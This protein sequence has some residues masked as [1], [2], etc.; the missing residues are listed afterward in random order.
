M[1]FAQEIK[2]FIAGAQAGQKMIGASSDE[3]YKAAK[4]K[5]LEAQ[6]TTLVNKNN[7]EEGDKLTK[8]AQRA[9]IRSRDAATALT[10]RRGALVDAQRKALT[11]PPTPPATDPMLAGLK[12]T[13]SS[14][15]TDV[16]APA[17]AVG[18]P[19]AGLSPDLPPTPAVQPSAI[20]ATS[21]VPADTD[22]DPV[23]A[24]SRGGSVQKFADGGAVGEAPDEEDPVD[25]GEPSPE[26]APMP[27]AVGGASD[28][29]DISARSRGTPKFSADA[30]L[31]A[32]KAGL[33]YAVTT[34]GL[35]SRAAV[36]DPQRQ[37][38]LKAY[39]SGAGAAQSTD[40]VAVRKAIDPEG[41]LGESSANLA[42]L[43]AVYQYKMN[44]GDEAGAQRAAFAM[45][46]HYRVSS[47]QY[48][49][50]AAAAAEKG[51]LDNATK[52]VMKSYAN[53]PDGKDLKLSKTEDGKIS[54]S[55]TDEKTGKVI[56]K[57]IET[58]DKLA[59]TAIGFARGQG[60]DAA[61]LAAAGQ[62]AEKPAKG[63]KGAVDPDA[64][65]KSA[66]KKTVLTAVNQAYDDQNPA[67]SEDE[68]KPKRDKSEERALRGASFRIAAHPANNRLTPDEAV[69]VATKIADPAALGKSTLKVDKA[70]GGYMVSIDKRPPTFVTA[71]DMGTLMER[72]NANKAGLDKKAKDDAAPGFAARAVKTAGELAAPVGDYLQ[73][74]RHGTRKEAAQEE[75]RR[76]TFTEPQ[77]P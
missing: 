45:I 13:M 52:L 15:T 63:A 19:D 55:F 6:T 3:K 23:A 36:A 4:Q 66:D 61:L 76:K 30:A 73:S 58:P 60:F 39:A 67:A 10:G 53:V 75:A 65:M 49:A 38:R 62:P 40:I 70:E 43:G 11:A 34:F 26:E 25:D 35:D 71:A 29:T 32:G 47:Q 68:S 56:S 12:P 7:D 37:H 22:T 51:D 50:M 9:L 54:Y 74:L 14:A 31:D 77:I 27:P 20:P 5:Y 41:K 18:G 1:S 44:K 69:D 72:R 33:K 17:P 8:D 16:P 21:D 42:A 24:Y 48:A 2:D 59:A 64:P 28:A 46:Q 57:G